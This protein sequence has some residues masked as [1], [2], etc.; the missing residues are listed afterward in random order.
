MAWKDTENIQKFISPIFEAHSFKW[1]IIYGDNASSKMV[2]LT[3]ASLPSASCNIYVQCTLIINEINY[4]CKKLA[5]YDKDMFL[6]SF[7]FK[8]EIKYIN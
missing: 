6:L 7:P 8:Y 1:F 2:Y 4:I 5:V 3:L